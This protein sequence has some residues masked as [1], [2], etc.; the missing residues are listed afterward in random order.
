MRLVLGFQQSRPC[1]RTAKTFAQVGAVMSVA[2]RKWAWQVCAKPSAKLVLLCL[3]E[4][5]DD[6]GLCWPSLR[7]IS[8]LTRL[9]HATV[10]R[11]LACL[12]EDGHINRQR[13]KGGQGH[14]TKY[15][16]A[17]GECQKRS[18]DDPV[19]QAQSETV[20]VRNSFITSVEQ[21]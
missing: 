3:A 17:I 13:G 8:E 11:C 19:K 10:T 20:A 18:H 9:S 14:S 16:L 5:A 4:H 6:D 21:S 12:E 1:T 15:Q 7:R 2:A